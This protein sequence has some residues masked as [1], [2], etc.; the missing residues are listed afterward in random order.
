MT[1][2][3]TS[4]KALT[5]VLSAIAIAALTGLVWP[6]AAL[7]QSGP[8]LAVDEPIHDIGVVEAGSDVT[9][10]FVLRNEGDAV[11]TI[12]DVEPDCGCTVVSYDR[13]IAPGGSGE[14]TARIDIST[15]FGPIAK[16]LVVH[17]NDSA[18]PEISLAIKV[19]VRP[20]VEVHPGYARFLTVVGEEAEPVDQVIWASDIDDLE[21]RNVRS[22]YSFVSAR[23]RQAKE[24]EERSEG[25][26]QQ[27]VIEVELASDAPIG[28]MAG[29]IE[30]ET[31]HPQKPT[32]RIP[33][34]GFVRPI[35]AASPPFADFG[36]REIT[37][38]VRAS[39]EIKNFSEEEIS[40]TEVVSS[41]SQIDT[42]IQVDGD[43][44]Y[45]I[46]ILNP[47]LPAG[48]FSGTVTVTTTSQRVPTLEIEVR[49]TV[50]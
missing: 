45:I 7:S 20:L 21:V 44:H 43:D 8:S 2:R 17:T 9:H 29:H 23:A 22:P 34:S 15:F 48:E 31:N 36:P 12:V 38:P 50:L 37:G 11:L 46:M 47:G 10:T 39:V 32:M 26:G 1:R 19:E 49:G 42:E 18:T 30:L 3:D 5:G 4:Q 6:G 13:S 41:L 14:V 40:L 27:W 24:G 35:L 28:P 25:Q 16:Y 33:V